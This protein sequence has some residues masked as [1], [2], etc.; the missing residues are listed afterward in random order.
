MKK[1]DERDTMFARMNYQ[2]GSQIY[3]DYYEK[4]PDKKAKDDE[5]R[6]LIKAHDRNN[7][8]Y[9]PFY[10]PIVDAN[11]EFLND[12]R[13]FSSGETSQQ[14]VDL[15]PQEAAKRLKKLAHY[16]GAD[17]VGITEMKEHFF[18]SHRGRH[19]ENY[20]DPVSKDHQYGIVFAVEM[21]QMMMNRAPQLEEAIEVT[22]GYVK[23][24][25]IGM[26][27]SYFIR[28]LGYDATNHMDGNYL[29]I[30]PL[31]AQSAGLGA[32]GR[33]NILTTKA[34][35]S[36]VRLGVVTT[37]LDL[38]TDEAS[39]F[40]IEKLCLACGKCANYCPGQAL[41]KE[42]DDWGINQERC[43]E[44][45]IKAGTDCGICIASCPI[46]QAYFDTGLL[47]QLTDDTIKS[48]LDEYDQLYD[49]RPYDNQKLDLMK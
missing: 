24:A 25:I 5:L 6:Q 18:Y 17:L 32:I 21:D 31:V 13:Q 41:S 47:E 8:T 12:I 9:D 7:L 16:F 28:K 37:N 45:W 20:G 14:V 30:A 22:Q 46:S 40:S 4:N 3:K 38:T 29:V 36:R 49:K 35:G 27:L 44:F 11:F 42:N 26:Q 39:S 15:S 48:L 34:Y 2:K 10:S 1:I 19:A 23:A 33:N 43:F